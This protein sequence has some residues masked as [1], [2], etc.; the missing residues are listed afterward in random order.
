MVKV[1][2]AENTVVRFIAMRKVLTVLFDA[3]VVVFLVPVLYLLCN[4]GIDISVLVDEIYSFVKVD[5]DMEKSLHTLSR[6]EYSGHHR[7]T[8]QLAEFL[9]VDGIA[10]F[11]KFIVHIQRTYHARMHIYELGC[12]IEVTL[13]VA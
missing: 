10:P 12:E 11:L 2:M 5:D 1:D 6:L 9:I 7:H 3:F 13:Q 4:L 8:K